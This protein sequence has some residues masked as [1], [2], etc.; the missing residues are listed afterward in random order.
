MGDLKELQDMAEQN[1]PKIK[2]LRAHL[3][4]AQRDLVA[5]R[6]QAYPR[7][8]A[9][10]EAWSYGRETSNRDNW[11][12]GIALHVPILQGGKVKAATAKAKAE[13]DYWQAQLQ[14]AI[15]EVRQ[16]VLETWLALKN[17]EKERQKARI[18]DDFWDLNLERSRT[19]REL[20]MKTNLGNSMM[21]TSE[22]RLK[23]AQANFKT[24]MAWA[25]LQ[26]LTGQDLNIKAIVE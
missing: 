11:R 6:K 14:Q 1:N 13:L 5:A 23:A 24:I 12:A 20:E 8:D 21:L 25:Q 17:L 4:A 18:E 16:A 15:L 10:M 9:E 19:L 3:L 7:I 26:A 2:A 22:A